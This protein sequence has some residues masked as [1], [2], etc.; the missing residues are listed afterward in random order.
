M[1]YPETSFSVPVLWN[2]DWMIQN[3]FMFTACWIWTVVFSP[4]NHRICCPKHANS[5]WNVWCNFWVICSDS[6]KSTSYEDPAYSQSLVV[7]VLASREKVF[8]PQTLN[9]QIEKQWF[10]RTI[11]DNHQSSINFFTTLVFSLC[12]L[13]IS[14]LL[15]FSSPLAPVSL[16]LE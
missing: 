2:L 5:I 12:S 11:C 9:F 16:R 6:S 10:P 1:G 8:M 13:Y 7:L 3:L 14:S 15:L 4:P